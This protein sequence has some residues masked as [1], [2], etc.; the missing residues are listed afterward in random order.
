VTNPVLTARL[1][2]QLPVEVS[3]EDDLDAVSTLLTEEAAAHPGILD[4]PA[5]S[6]RLTE[7]ADNGVVLSVRAWIADPARSEYVRVR[8]AVAT[9]IIERLDDQDAQLSPPS[10]HEL[11]GGIGTEEG[12]SEALDGGT[13]ER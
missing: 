11:S 1:R 10:E 6:V 13:A 7:F 12:T 3:Y 9:R 4:E 2:L 8:S 5:P